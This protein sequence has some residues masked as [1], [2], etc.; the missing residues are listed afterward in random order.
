MRH[1][2]VKRV[3]VCDRYGTDPEAPWTPVHLALRRIAKDRKLSLAAY[4]VLI[5][6]LDAYNPVFAGRIPFSA[7]ALEKLLPITRR[8][9]GAALEE[10]ESAGLLNIER[11]AGCRMILY[12]EPLLVALRLE[13]SRF[14]RT[15]HLPLL[16]HEV[17]HLAAGRQVGRQPG[18]RGPAAGRQGGGAPLPPAGS[19]DAP[20]QQ[21]ARV[22]G[23]REKEW[24]AEMLATIN[25]PKRKAN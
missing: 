11:P 2:G 8:H 17:G 10:I 15:G 19:T 22:A 9:V 3:R 1:K 18:A 4:V 16:R 14:R 7:S 25:R 13:C 6:V 12:V 24:I 20:E 21:D 5:E 23:G